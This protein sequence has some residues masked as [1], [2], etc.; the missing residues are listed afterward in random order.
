MVILA[1][2]PHP[3]FAQFDATDTL[4]PV[5]GVAVGGTGVGV[6]AVGDGVC[7]PAPDALSPAMSIT[8]KRKPPARNRGR[9]R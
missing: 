4:P 5:T 8:A 3:R 9:M 6:G 7:A 1:V 2:S